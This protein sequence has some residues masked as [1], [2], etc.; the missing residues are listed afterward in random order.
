MWGRYDYGNIVIIE[1]PKLISRWKETRQDR[2]KGEISYRKKETKK[3]KQKWI[4]QKG[5]KIIKNNNK[6]EWWITK[7]GKETIEYKKEREGMWIT[8]SGEK[9]METIKRKCG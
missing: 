7:K 8:E 2:W 9:T 6:K 4:T 5:K 1:A 3:G